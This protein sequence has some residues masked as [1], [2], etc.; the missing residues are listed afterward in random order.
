MRGDFIDTFKK[1][2][3]IS[4]GKHFFNIFPQTGNF[5]SNQ[6]SK[7]KSINQLDFLAICSKNI[8]IRSK[9]AILFFKKKLKINFDDFRNNKKKI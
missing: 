5:L 7:T 6:I 3:G 1:I 4:N 2:N 8:L 9:T